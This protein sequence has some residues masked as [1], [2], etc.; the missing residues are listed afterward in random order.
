MFQGMTKTCVYLVA[1]ASMGCAHHAAVPEDIHATPSQRKVLDSLITGNPGW[2]LA[3]ASDNRRIPELQRA[4]VPVP[5]EPYFT[6][7]D[8]GGGEGSFAAALVKSDTFSVFYVRRDG[9]HYRTPQRV[10]TAD[11]LD[12]GRIV[13]QGDTLQVGPLSSDQ[14]F[15][16]VWNPLSQ[17]MTLR[18]GSE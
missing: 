15:T 13:L 5:P 1:L 11:W 3:R 17:A 7:T 8:T 18:P 4:G 6:A 14:I 2:R 16:F 9:Q 10:T 12:R